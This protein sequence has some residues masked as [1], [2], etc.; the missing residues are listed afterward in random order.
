MEIS[1]EVPYLHVTKII[2]KPKNPKS[3]LAVTG[4]YFYDNS[5]FDKIAKLSFSSRGELEITDLNM[6]YV[7]EGTA[8]AYKVDGYWGDMGTYDGI[9]E[10]SKFVKE[11]DFKLSYEIDAWAK[12]S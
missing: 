10:A 12:D 1:P 5:L 2:E 8:N 7:E 9:F 3:N 6:L 11:T 4:L